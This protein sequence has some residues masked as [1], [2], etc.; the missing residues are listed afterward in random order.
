MEQNNFFSNFLL[1]KSKNSDKIIEVFS[2]NWFLDQA[3]KDI[4]DVKGISI[5]NSINRRL[6]I[7]F[8]YILRAYFAIQHLLKIIT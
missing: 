3:N 7:K 4:F 5:S 8:T 1:N 2:K 6:S